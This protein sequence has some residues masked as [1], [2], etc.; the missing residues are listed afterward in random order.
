L[1]KRELAVN[2][3]DDKRMNIWSK[4]FRKLYSSSPNYQF[5]DFEIAD[6][7]L[8]SIGGCKKLFRG[9]CPSHKDLM[10]GNYICL[11]GAAQFFGRSQKIVTTTTVRRI[12]SK[13]GQEKRRDTFETPWP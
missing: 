11:L 10:T 2:P 7:E 4:C 3:T 9:P 1:V 8:F 5:Q 12:Q 13:R 6:Y